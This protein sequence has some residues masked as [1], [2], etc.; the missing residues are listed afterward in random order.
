MRDLPSP[1]KGK[2]GW[3]SA[4]LSSQMAEPRRSDLE[5]ADADPDAEEDYRQ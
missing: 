3:G 5:D 1:Q 4:I 2:E